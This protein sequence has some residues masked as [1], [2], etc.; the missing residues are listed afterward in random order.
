MLRLSKHGGLA[1]SA[2]LRHA[3]DDNALG[4]RPVQIRKIKNFSPFT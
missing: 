3:Q 4:V 2:I 1:L